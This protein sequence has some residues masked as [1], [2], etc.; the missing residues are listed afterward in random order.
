VDSAPSEALSDRVDGYDV[1]S[2][3]NS[4]VL[5]SNIASATS[6]YQDNDQDD[7][8]S[9][10]DCDGPHTSEQLDTTADAANN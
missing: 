6:Q 7:L 1:D 2:A 10:E 3:D 4:V 5:E 9:R 8:P